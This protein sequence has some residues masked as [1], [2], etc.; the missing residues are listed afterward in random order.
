VREKTTRF[1]LPRPGRKL[2]WDRAVVDARCCG[3]KRR[4]KFAALENPDLRSRRASVLRCPANSGMPR[5]HQAW[6]PPVT[7]GEVLADPTGEGGATKQRARHVTRPFALRMEATGACDD[8][9]AFGA[10]VV[11]GRGGVASG[12]PHSSPSRDSEAR[13]ASPGSPRRTPPTIFR[14]ELPAPS[15]RETRGRG[16]AGKALSA[17]GAS[18]PGMNQTRHGPPSKTVQRRFNEWPTE[19]SIHPTSSSAYGSWRKSGHPPHRSGRKEN[20][21]G[22][23]RGFEGRGRAAGGRVPHRPEVRHSARPTRGRPG[24]RTHHGIRRGEGRAVSE[25]CY[26]PAPPG[27]T[28]CVPQTPVRDLGAPADHSGNGRRAFR[29]STTSTTSG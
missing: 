5:V 10:Q 6:A 25:P 15:P 2:S 19:R 14:N 16:M 26:L 7:V 11:P 28:G 13:G 9:S 20:A 12:S 24:P 8:T 4:S 23:S 17:S 18:P 21:S 22:E 1:D 3:K 27:C 29:H